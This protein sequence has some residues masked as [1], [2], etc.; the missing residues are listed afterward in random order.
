MKP[1]QFVCCSLAAPALLRNSTKLCCNAHTFPIF[2]APVCRHFS[3]GVGG[4]GIFALHIW[5][6]FGLFCKCTSG[7]YLL[8]K[9]KLALRVCEAEELFCYV[10]P[11][12]EQ[13]FLS[14]CIA[15]HFVN[16]FSPSWC[17]HPSQACV[18]FLHLAAPSLKQHIHRPSSLARPSRH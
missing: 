6:C 12:T 5:C 17:L 18:G 2:R 13:G 4:E 1:R 16:S 8:Q 7:Y 9:A 3:L 15:P 10:G 11:V 14:C